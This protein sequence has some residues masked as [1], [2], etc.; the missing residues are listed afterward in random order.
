MHFHSR[1]CIWKCR[2]RNGVH[3]SGSQCVKM[4]PQRI[5][6]SQPITQFSRPKRAITILFHNGTLCFECFWYKIWQSS[7]DRCNL[8]SISARISNYIPGEIWGDRLDPFMCQ[9]LCFKIKPGCIAKQQLIM[10]NAE[11]ISIS[12]IYLTDRN[13]FCILLL[14]SP[15]YFVRSKLH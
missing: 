4:T 1:K 13:N 7:Y 3:L 5:A 12:Q 14:I 10:Q 15:L 9:L 2:L 8:T 11:I 6:K